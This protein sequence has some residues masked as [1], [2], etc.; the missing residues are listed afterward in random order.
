MTCWSQ[1]LASSVRPG[2][3]K[4]ISSLSAIEGRRLCAADAVLHGLVFRPDI[5][6]WY[7][8]LGPPASKHG[9]VHPG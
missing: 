6:T 1:I 8:S 7:F 4:I 2:F 5:R 9:G 3:S